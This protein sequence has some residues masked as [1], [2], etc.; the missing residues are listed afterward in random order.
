[1]AGKG[2]LP[3]IY[4]PAVAQ[5]YDENAQGIILQAGDDA[6]VT[7]AVL[8]E[9]TQPRTFQGFA[10]AAR[11]FEQ[12]EAAMQEGQYAPGGLMIE[13]VQFAHGGAIQLNPPGHS[14]S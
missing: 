13:L 14:A 8:P 1:M 3:S 4:I 6:V 10:D 12:G 5:A 9:L 2:A 11:V 7:D